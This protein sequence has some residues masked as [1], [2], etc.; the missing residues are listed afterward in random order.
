MQ[1]SRWLRFRC[2][3]TCQGQARS[4]PEFLEGKGKLWRRKT[5]CLLLWEWKNKMF[6]PILRYYTCIDKQARTFVIRNT[7]TPVFGE[8][9]SFSIKILHSEAYLSL[10]FHKKSLFVFIGHYYMVHSSDKWPLGIHRFPSR[11]PTCSV[12]KK[13]A[14]SPAVSE[15][16]H[17]R[18]SFIL[19]WQ[20]AG[21]AGFC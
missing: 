15:E 12:K 19:S 17:F 2:S 18:V 13:P 3:F 14:S 20:T 9:W 11:C 7:K 21:K 10:N 8:F 4:Q 5:F 16:K 1:A 6:V